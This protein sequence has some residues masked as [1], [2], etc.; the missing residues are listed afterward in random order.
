MLDLSIKCPV[1]SVSR[2]DCPFVTL[3]PKKN[4]VPL[5]FLLVSVLLESW[6]KVEQQKVV[7][8][9][10]LFSL[11]TFSKYPLV[12]Q[13]KRVWQCIHS[14]PPSDKL[15]CPLVKLWQSWR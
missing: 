3:W 7:N 9:R 6:D 5:F 13:K 10:C 11:N 2:E 12:F 8:E 1:P 4:E 14:S 15:L